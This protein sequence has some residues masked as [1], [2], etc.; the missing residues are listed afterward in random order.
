MATA[1]MLTIGSR[2]SQLALW[3]ARFVAGRL[4]NRGVATRIEIIRTTGDR[5]QTASLV[6]AG[7]K[8]LFTRE[9][10]EALLAGA[11]DLAV[12]SLKDLPTETPEGLALA[13]MPERENPFDAMVGGTLAGLKEGARVGTSSSRRAAQLRMLRPDLTI[14][15]IR[16]NVDTRLRKRRE[17]EFDAILL[18]VAGLRRLG[19]DGEIAQIFTADEI[20]PAPGQGALA[21]ETRAGDEAFAICGGLNDQPTSQAVLCERTVLKELGGGCQLPVGA[22]AEMRG[23]ILHVTAAVVAPDGSKRLRAEG[24]GED[25]GELGRLIAAELIER[26]ARE[27]LAASV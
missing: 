25:A 22:F 17:G 24:E 7:G 18:A 6:Q 19:L 14:E 15:P 5:W 11:I 12:H 23:A 1:R 20:C 4:E 27:I 13:A 3:Q 2:G 16:G 9:I 10:E 26:G 8:G 21:I